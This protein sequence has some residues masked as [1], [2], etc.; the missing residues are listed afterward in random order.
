[1]RATTTSARR[2]K[3]SATPPAV[4]LGGE[5]IAVAVAR[6]LGT[7]GVRVYALGNAKYDPVAHSR[8][9]HRFIDLGSGRGVQDR[10]LQWLAEHGDGFA[11]QRPVV[12]PCNDDGLELVA[13]NRDFLI[14]LGY[15]PMEANDDAVLAMLDKERTYELAR[16]AGVSAPRTA[17]LHTFS[18]LDV[19]ADRFDYPCALKPRHSHQF[20]RKFGVRTKA[21][22]A[23]DR[24]EL[25][26]IAEWLA[27]L[28]VDMMVTE[29]I[30][31]LDDEYRSYYSYLDENGWP[32]FHFTKRKLRQFPPGFG[33]GTYHITDWDE[34]VA[35]TGLRFLQAVG[36]LGLANVEFKRD[37]RDG[38]LAL[39]ECNHRFTAASELVRRAGIDLGVFVYNRVLG[40]PQPEITTY[41]RGLRLW[42]P[43]EDARALVPYRRR[44]EL[45]FGGWIRS[46]AHRQTFPLFS[47]RDPKPA[48]FSWSRLPLRAIRKLRW[49]R[50]GDSTATITPE[51]PPNSAEVT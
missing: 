3:S 11:S 34:E 47:V 44:G 49:R 8:H 21:F 19:I 5:V 29:I 13:R 48:F 37:A 46:I 27:P 50:T 17:T 51:L 32:L 22:V 15:Q 42:C 28:E 18:Q 41:R 33:L 24:E 43:V 45:S 2:H 9:C 16:A 40:R 20:A 30:P 39:I 4:L 31:G 26:R 14:G 38:T 12:L 23:N 10:W 6:G 7:I 25:V 36:V 35:E 1:M